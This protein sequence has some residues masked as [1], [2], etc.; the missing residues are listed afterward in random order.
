MALSFSQSLPGS[1][2]YRWTEIKRIGP[3]EKIQHGQQ[4]ESLQWDGQ[5]FRF[6]IYF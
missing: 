2:L 5:R 6:V 1:G 3:P 4:T